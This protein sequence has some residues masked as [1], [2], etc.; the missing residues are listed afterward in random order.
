MNSIGGIRSQSLREPRP[1]THPTAPRRK[2]GGCRFYSDFTSLTCQIVLLPIQLDYDQVED[3]RRV[4]GTREASTRTELDY[5]TDPE[6]SP[7]MASAKRRGC[8]HAGYAVNEWH[9]AYPHQEQATE[10]RSNHMRYGPIMRWDCPKNCGYYREW[11]ESLEFMGLVIVHP[12]YGRITEEVLIYTDI[13]RH[14]CRLAWMARSRSP[15]S[16]VAQTTVRPVPGEDGG[17]LL[18]LGQSR[19]RVGQIRKV[20]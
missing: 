16:K 11:N 17:N 19:A 4:P 2:L 6:E 18:A 7:R 13:T 8:F 15:K 14:S 10:G 20:G 9:G 12:I 3:A 1:A 5:R